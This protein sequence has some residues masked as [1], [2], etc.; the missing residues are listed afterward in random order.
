MNN[1]LPAPAFFDS[2][3][4]DRNTERKKSAGTGGVN[5]H[6]PA[7]KMDMVVIRQAIP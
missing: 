1:D 3:R 6:I 7:D 5:S 4:K 2:L